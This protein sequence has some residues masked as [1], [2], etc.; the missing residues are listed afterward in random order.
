MAYFNTAGVSSV[1]VQMHLL[2][3]M[4]VLLYPGLQQS[5]GFISFVDLPQECSHSESYS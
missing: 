5:A 1:Q 3:R 2:Q 4:V